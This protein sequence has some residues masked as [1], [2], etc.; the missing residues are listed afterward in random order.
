MPAS[1]TPCGTA[2]P[3]KSADAAPASQRAPATTTLPTI[4]A[5]ALSLLSW[6]C[7]VV[8]RHPPPRPSGDAEHAVVGVEQLLFPTRPG[9]SNHKGSL[10]D[11]PQPLALRE[12]G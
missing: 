9:V 11:T 12:L 1:G 10:V 4:A 6:D 2:W 5:I 8:I 7:G 3:D